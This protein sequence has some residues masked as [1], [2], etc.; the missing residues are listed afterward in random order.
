MR[1][2]D[3]AQLRASFV[4]V[5]VRERKAIPLPDLDEVAW[6]EID[7]LGWRDPK[8]PLVAYAVAVVD[9]AP[10]GLLLRQAEQSPR[11]RT[12]C[13]WCQDVHL[14][15]DVVMFSARR[16]GAAGRRGDTIGTYVCQNFECNVNARATPRMAYVG[17]DV[18]GARAARMAAF[19]GNVERFMRE[20]LATA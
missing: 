9:D 19:R 4:N 1:I 13:A 2:L 8:L 5:S 7:V 3:A 12:Q 17:F 15:N 6:E 10:V 20:V 11:R 16:A 18:E 14:P